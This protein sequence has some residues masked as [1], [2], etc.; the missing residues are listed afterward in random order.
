[1]DVTLASVELEGVGTGTTDITVD[2]Q[3]LDD[4]DGAAI[5]PQ[6]RPGVVVTGPPP[7]GGGPGGS[8]RAPTDPDGDGRFED[9]NG[10]GRLDYNDV[11]LLFDHIEDDSVTL[12]ADAYDFNENGRIDYDDI[13]ELYDEL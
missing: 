5:E 7:I 13:D 8:G 11:V 12:N 9:S 10:N 1:M 3:A 4:D 6:R 2:V